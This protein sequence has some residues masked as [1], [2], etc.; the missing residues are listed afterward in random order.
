MHWLMRQDWSSCVAGECH[1]RTTCWS[2]SLPFV[3]LCAK[4]VSETGP[5]EPIEIAV[6][7]KTGGVPA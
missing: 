3:I 2:P 4:H 1:S 6:K 5:P 7:E